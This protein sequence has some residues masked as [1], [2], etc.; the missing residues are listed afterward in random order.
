MIIC[1]KA[2]R[3]RTPDGFNPHNPKHAENAPKPTRGVFC[4]VCTL[5]S[6]NKC[7]VIDLHKSKQR[8]PRILLIIVKIWYM[9]RA[10]TF[11]VRGMCG[12]LW[13]GK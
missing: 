9:I 2:E 4:E 5:T 3:Y 12:G 1:Y 8:F 10:V 6:K 7:S 13:Y 11:L